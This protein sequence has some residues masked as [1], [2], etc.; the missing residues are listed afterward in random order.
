[1]GRPRRDGPASE[2]ARQLVGGTRS[3]R[4]RTFR[5]SRKDPWDR[6]EAGQTERV[7]KSKEG[8]ETA[9]AQQG[10]LPDG[11]ARRVGTTQSG[12]DGWGWALAGRVPLAHGPMALGGLCKH[13]GQSAER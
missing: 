4:H 12:G 9:P 13:D 6:G 10:L 5:K 1:M 8:G 2:W 11:S 3:L 7:D